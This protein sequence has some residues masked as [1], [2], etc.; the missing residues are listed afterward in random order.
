MFRQHLNG[1]FCL[2]LSY[3]YIGIFFH[4]QKEISIEAKTQLSRFYCDK[5]WCFVSHVSYYLP[6]FRINLQL[7]H[8]VEQLQFTLISRRF[9]PLVPLLVA[10][11][12]WK[13]NVWL[14]SYR[15]TCWMRLLGNG[16]CSHWMRWC[17]LTIHSFIDVC[18]QCGKST[19]WHWQTD[20]M[21]GCVPSPSVFIPYYWTFRHSYLESDGTRVLSSQKIKP[22]HNMTSLFSNCYH[23]H[24]TCKIYPK[25][26]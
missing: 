25:F 10:V 6:I 9:R 26:D 18:M 13:P 3:S 7:P 1:T 8:P 2:I 16:Q 5:T 17:W 14:T 11:H 19:S 22:K 24:S 21:C 12:Y 20:E 15:W 4:W 23:L